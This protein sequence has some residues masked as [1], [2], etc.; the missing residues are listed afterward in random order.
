MFNVQGYCVREI[1]FCKVLG[2]ERCEQCQGGYQLVNGNCFIVD[3]YCETY[4]EKLQG[5]IRCVAGY[6]SESGSCRLND[7]SCAAYDSSAFTQRCTRCA[8]GYVYTTDGLNCVKQTPGCIYNAQGK[9]TSCRAPFTFNGKVCVIYACSKYSDTGCYECEY[10]TV[11]QDDTCVIP[12]CEAY[13]QGSPACQK[14]RAGYKM[15][16]GK[17]YREDPKCIDYTRT[18]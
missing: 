18:G 10:P 13:E 3:K 6:H 2:Y 8:T 11:R 15:I 9:C 16:Q 14:C 4:D 5:C 7:Q 17:C 12:F 1:A